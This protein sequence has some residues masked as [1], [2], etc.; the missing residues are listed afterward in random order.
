M[1]TIR[2]LGAGL[3]AISIAVMAVSAQAATEAQ[4]RA[5]IDNGLA[6][7]A[8]Q[9]Q[10]DG[11]W[12]YDNSAEG[13]TSAT[14][15]TLLA[16]LEEKP[17][18]GANAATY[19]TIVDN[20]LNYLFS[21]TQAVAIGPQPAG[22]PDTNGNGIGVK[23]VTGGLNGRDTY[24][25]GLVLPAI[26]ASGTPNAVITT[27]SQAGRTYGQ[28]VQDV[29]D[30]FAYGQ[31]DAGTGVH[32]GG[33]RYYAN[34]GT[35]DNSTAQWPPVA[36]LYAQSFGATVP[37]FVKNELKNYIDNIQCGAADARF[38]GSGYDSACGG[39]APVSE[40]KT[41]G[42][43][44]EMAFAGYNGYKPGDTLGRNEALAY[45]NTN[46]QNTASA[47]WQGNFAHP[48]AMW[49][50]YKGLET[51]IGVDADTSIIGNLRPGDCGGNVDNPDHGCNWFED[52]AEYLVSSQNAAG[53]WTGYSY[54]NSP[55]ATPWYINILA[56]TKIPNGDIPEPATLA[57]A[58]LALA[59]LAVS[60][61]RK[62]G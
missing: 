2:T 20:G 56:A 54:W 34:N 45:L 28:V 42:L 12:I 50:I 16:F 57:L 7:L 40:S 9:Q 35:S 30:Y 62:A 25:T 31:N 53:N 37:Q 3:T 46:W 26:V 4:K 1:T 14:G 23:F 15:A 18:W 59:G 5:A 33:W 49:S 39:G 6:Y 21:K 13:D 29:V 48:Y 55:L 52:M 32:Q 44:L 8:T 27:G 24:V 51:T 60:R 58:G 19:Q 10:A 47:T 17:N 41:G 61:R 22:N 38:G 43:L 11:R 36:M